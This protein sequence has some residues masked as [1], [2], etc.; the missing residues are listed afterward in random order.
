MEEQV[1]HMMLRAEMMS[2]MRPCYE[3]LILHVSDVGSL[4]GTRIRYEVR[5]ANPQETIKIT[6]L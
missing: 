5:A 6:S 1:K 3:V 4:G 2:E